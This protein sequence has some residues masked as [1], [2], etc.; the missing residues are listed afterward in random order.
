ML[1]RLIS[2]GEWLLSK[3]VKQA[4]PSHLRPASV[5]GLNYQENLLPSISQ[6]PKLDSELQR[7]HVDKDKTRLNPDNGGKAW[8]THLGNILWVLRP[9]LWS[10]RGGVTYLRRWRP[11]SVGRPRVTEGG[12]LGQPG[13]R[14]S[15]RAVAAS[16]S[17][18]RGD[19]STAPRQQFH[20]GPAPEGRGAGLP[21][22]RAPPLL[23]SE[24][25]GESGP[26]SLLLPRGSVRGPGPLS[27]GTWLLPPRV[28]ARG[29]PCS[30]Q[31]RTPPAPPTLPFPWR[32]AVPTSGTA[33]REASSGQVSLEGCATSGRGAFPEDHCK[34]A[35]EFSLV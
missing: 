14:G 23:A 13:G 9:T 18:G 7:R 10:C 12:D 3:H 25:A 6:R 22:L 24:G 30:A 19:L 32:A 29:R 33:D 35:L 5:H 1:T 28:P 34:P 26:P 27:P 20:G 16:V 2:G 4:L 31:T 17:G 21:K 8:R 11:G 15:V